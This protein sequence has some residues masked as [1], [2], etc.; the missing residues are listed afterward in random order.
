MARRA[1]RHIGESLGSAIFHD[2]P[3]IQP[4]SLPRALPTTTH[5]HVLHSRFRQWLELWGRSW[6]RSGAAWCHW[7]SCGDIL[8]HP[9]PCAS[10]GMP[11]LLKGTRGGRGRRAWRGL[12]HSCPPSLRAALLAA[13][14]QTRA[15]YMYTHSC[16]HTPNRHLPGTEVDVD[17]EGNSGKGDESYANRH[18]A[19]TRPSHGGLRRRHAYLRTHTH[20]HNTKVNTTKTYFLGAC[21]GDGSRCGRGGQIGRGRGPL[22]KEMANRHHAHKR[23]SSKLAVSQ[24]PGCALRVHSH[25]VYTRPCSHQLSIRHLCWGRKQMQ[26][27]R[28]DRERERTQ[29]RRDGEQAS[30]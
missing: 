14:T 22:R 15:H 6:S 11:N 17:E 26:A 19:P 1:L 7:S 21:A 16:L 10:Q 9:G 18:H 25:T 13:Y 30:G 28:A 23:Q 2:V 5:A 3:I 24:T 4:A 20:T 29:T 27:R 12:S 8:F